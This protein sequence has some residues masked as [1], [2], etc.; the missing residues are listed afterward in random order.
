MKH[1]RNLTSILLATILG[2]TSVVLSGVKIT[3]DAHAVGE[4][5]TVDNP[6]EVSNIT[7]KDVYTV[8]ACYATFAAAQSAMN[9]LSA[10]QPNV[11]IRHSL[12]FSPSKIIA[13][14]R[15]I[16][17]TY[18]SRSDSSAT[19][20]LYASYNT[21]T[22]AP[23]NALTYMTNHYDMQ[24]LGTMGYNPTAGNGIIKIKV[25]GFTGYIDLK[26]SDLIPM[27]YIENAWSFTLGGTPSTSPLVEAPFTMVPK[28]NRYNAFTAIERSAQFV[29]LRT[30]TGLAAQRILL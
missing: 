28:M 19:I 20:N 2:L 24:Y 16:A 30:G 15:G 12:S 1:L 26:N 21:T 6:F 17:V 11:V 25:S 4:I 8:N 14:D 7:A 3:I 10:T 27:I 9:T 18:D 5:C 29:H 23:V 13:M 22:L